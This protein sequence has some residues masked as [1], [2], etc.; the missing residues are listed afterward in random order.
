M[1]NCWVLEG[2][3]DLDAVPHGLF[4]IHRYL[5]LYCIV[6][7]I[8]QDNVTSLQFLA[9]KVA[10]KPAMNNDPCRFIIIIH[11]NNS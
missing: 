11:A 6:L 10:N 8:V 9:I 1:R 2:D 4:V 5:I 7:K 3:R